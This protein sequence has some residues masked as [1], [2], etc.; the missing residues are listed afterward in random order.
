M[1][2]VDVLVLVVLILNGVLGAFRG[3][4]SQ[5]FRIGSLILA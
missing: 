4:V 5:A 3:F 2:T 1:N